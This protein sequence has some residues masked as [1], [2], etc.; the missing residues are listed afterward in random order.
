MR[1]EGSFAGAEGFP[2]TRWDVVG[3]GYFRTLGIRLVAGRDFTE[4]DDA[5][6]PAVIAINE[7]MARRL[8]GSNDALGRRLQW[9]GGGAIPLQI[10]AI[11][12]DV[13]VGGPR[14]DT[15][16]R[17][18]IPYL[19]LPL[20]DRLDSGQPAFAHSHHPPIP[21]SW[22]RLLR[23]LARPKHSFGRAGRDRFRSREPGDRPGTIGRDTSRNLQHTGGRPGLRRCV[24]PHQLPGPSAAERNR[25][26]DGARINAGTRDVDHAESG[27]GMDVDRDRCRHSDGPARRSRSKKSSVRIDRDQRRHPHDL[28][29][30][31]VRDWTARS[32]PS[33]PAGITNRSARR[34][35]LRLS[36]PRSEIAEPPRAPRSLQVR[37]PATQR[38][39]SDDHSN[40]DEIRDPQRVAKA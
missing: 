14:D 6:S 8:F 39:H 7:A 15:Q 4:H 26:P 31:D 10:V 25:P 27:P 16:L 3:P 17:F 11:V 23:T 29:G 9:G 34:A 28:G 12:G 13:K 20:F 40:P 21:R 5:G 2:H 18:Y 1:P 38:I 32:V 22:G 24:W 33:G 19:Q 35:P 30:R 36:R 37:I